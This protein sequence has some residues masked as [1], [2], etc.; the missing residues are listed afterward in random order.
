VTGGTPDF[1]HTISQISMTLVQRRYDMVL[2]VY[3][4]V[5]IS[6]S[7]IYGPHLIFSS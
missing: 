4:K 5:I 7:Q 2:L 6:N 1:A 3:V